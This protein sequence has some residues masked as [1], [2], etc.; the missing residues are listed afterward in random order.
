MHQSGGLPGDDAGVDRM[1]R[2][3]RDARGL[4]LGVL[5]RP[6]RAAAD[7]GPADRGH[8]LERAVVRR[9]PLIRDGVLDDLRTAGEALLQRGL[10]V[11]R[12]GERVGDLRLEGLDDGGCRAL[13]A[14]VQ[15]A[16]ADHRLDHRCEHALGLDE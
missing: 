14:A 4:L 3:E 12:V 9:P 2:L 5:L 16:G 6:P 10:E 7:G 1:Q 13:V 15:I 8:D 11:D